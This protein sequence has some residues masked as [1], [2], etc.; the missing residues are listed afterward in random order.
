METN[1]YSQK[2]NVPLLNS[3][4]ID[5]TSPRGKILLLNKNIS[6]PKML[7]VSSLYKPREDILGYG[8]RNPWKTYEYK[9]YLFIPILALVARKN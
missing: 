1:G 8:L 9:N 4:P 7:S 6:K 5:T 2:V 3:E